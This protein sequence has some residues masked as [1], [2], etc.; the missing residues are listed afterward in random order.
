MTLTVEQ[1]IRDWTESFE[2]TKFGPISACQRVRYIGCF[3]HDWLDA[4]TGQKREVTERAAHR[5]VG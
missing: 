3:G 4:S 5:G 1:L 2:R